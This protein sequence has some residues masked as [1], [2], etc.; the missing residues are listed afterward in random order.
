MN[1]IY[2]SIFFFIIFNNL[3]NLDISSHSITRT[4]LV[5]DPFIGEICVCGCSECVIFLDPINNH[6][7]PI[8]VHESLSG[9][10]KWVCLGCPECPGCPVFSCNDL[11]F[12]SQLSSHASIRTPLPET[13]PFYGGIYIYGFPHFFIPHYLE[14]VYICPLIYEECFCLNCLEWE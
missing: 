14:S 2:V 3:I 1:P 7:C 12:L 5:D 9:N 11:S 4:S 6:V 13:D 8:I 10:P